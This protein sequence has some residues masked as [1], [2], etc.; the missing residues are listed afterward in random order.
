M[1]QKIIRNESL[2]TLE[3]Y[4]NTPQTI[5]CVLFKAGEAKVIPADYISQQIK[6]LIK[7]RMISVSNY[8]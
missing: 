1:E 6:K 2:Q 7:R 4:L 5:K 8:N 3:V